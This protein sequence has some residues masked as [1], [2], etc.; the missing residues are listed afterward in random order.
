MFW[1]PGITD[2]E[3]D[4]LAL[5][6]YIASLTTVEKIEILP[7]HQLGKH[8]WKE[9]GDSYELK[10]TPDATTEDVERAKKLL[11]I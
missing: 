7:F 5:K 11:G 3:E 6:D 8:K 1:Y 9:Y 4:L 10:D 2:D